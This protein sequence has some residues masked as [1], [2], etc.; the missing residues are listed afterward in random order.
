M[1]KYLSYLSTIG[2]GIFVIGFLW[3][4]YQNGEVFKF[5]DGQI[6]KYLVYIGVLMTFPEY[7][8][9][10]IHFNEY[11]KENFGCFIYIGFILIIILLHLYFNK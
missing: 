3:S 9:K 1:K 4:W 2:L 7:I 8:Y 6:S 11:R 10:F 5:I